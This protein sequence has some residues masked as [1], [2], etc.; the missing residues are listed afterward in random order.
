MLEREI[1]C[2]TFGKV[3]FLFGFCALIQPINIVTSRS[4]HPIILIAAPMFYSRT[5]SIISYRDA[6]TFVE[7]QG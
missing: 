7:Y 4:V 3:P 2:V 5:N 6:E 1:V